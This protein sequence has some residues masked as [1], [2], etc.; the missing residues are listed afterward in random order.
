MNKNEINR[1]NT[2]ADWFSNEEGFN[3]RLI[4][5]VLKKIEPYLKGDSVL[6][7]GCA[8][9]KVSKVLPSYFDDITI[10]DGSEKYIS[11]VRDKLNNKGNFYV[12]LF[13]DFDIGKKFDVILSLHILEHVIDPISVL[14]KASKWLKPGGIMIISVPNALSIHRNIGVKMG[15][16]GKVD[17]LNERDL[18]LGHRRVYTPQL[19][20]DQL[21]QAGLN[22]INMGGAFLSPY[23]IHK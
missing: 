4:Y 20:K 18:K 3:S 10:V 19:L 23:Q 12:S 9:G 8:D 15:L 13:E 11:I 2:V 1:L 5:Y 22:V 21:S 17:E 7:L 6:E 16:L 14:E